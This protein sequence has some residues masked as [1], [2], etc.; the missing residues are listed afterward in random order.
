MYVCVCARVNTCS[1]SVL[2]GLQRLELLKYI[3]P[4]FVSGDYVPVHLWNKI[5][6]LMTKFLTI[7]D[8]YLAPTS[9][10]RPGPA[11]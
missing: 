7:Q 4:M 8:M 1:Y 5:N 3:N 2:L 10:T 9:L 6:I 11:F